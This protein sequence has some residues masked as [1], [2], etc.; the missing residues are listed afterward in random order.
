MGMTGSGRARVGLWDGI[1]LVRPADCT[2]PPLGRRAV[3]SVL[4]IA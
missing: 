4:A 3:G 2:C 1:N